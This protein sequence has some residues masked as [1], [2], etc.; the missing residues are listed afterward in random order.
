MEVSRLLN[1]GGGQTVWGDNAETTTVTKDKIKVS[2]NIV[3]KIKIQGTFFYHIQHEN[4]LWSYK[5]NMQHVA[6][7]QFIELV[8]E[9]SHTSRLKGFFTY[10]H[11]NMIVLCIKLL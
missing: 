3:T 2:E 11:E 6:R 4:G 8:C 10:V 7:T 9:D 1:V 5:Y